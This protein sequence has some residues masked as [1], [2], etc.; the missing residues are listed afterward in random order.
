MCL[1][2]GSKPQEA[3]PYCQNA[4]SV[5]KSRLQRLR[6][7]VKV[8]SGSASSSAA[9]ELDDG[10]QQSSNGAQTVKSVK[11]KEAEIETLAGLAE[12]LEKKASTIWIIHLN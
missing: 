5:C 11:D 3:I 10:V 8:S 12:D 9:S 2:I 1:E 7:E 4:I 6:D